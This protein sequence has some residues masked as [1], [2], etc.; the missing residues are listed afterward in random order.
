MYASTL[1]KI[2]I[3]YLE[4]LLVVQGEEG[5]EQFGRQTVWGTEQHL[6]RN[7]DNENLSSNREEINK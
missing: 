6:R 5:S 3:Q 1:S 7:F 2:V 4:S